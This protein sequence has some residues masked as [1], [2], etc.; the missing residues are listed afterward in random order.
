MGERN[1]P[2]PAATLDPNDCFTR[3]RASISH[4]H[5]PVSI[6][7]CCTL[8]QYLWAYGMR[9]VR[10]RMPPPP[11]PAALRDAPMH[12]VSEPALWARIV[13]TKLEGRT[14]HRA[15]REMLTHD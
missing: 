14:Q 9:W 12:Q 8:V 11:F 4:G 10:G 7:V 6:F 1:I 5:A 15:L 13:L 2:P 3:A